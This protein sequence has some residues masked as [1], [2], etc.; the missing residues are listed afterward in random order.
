V[1][2]ARDGDRRQHLERER[3]L[4]P[5]ERA[6]IEAAP[7]GGSTSSDGSSASAVRFGSRGAF[8]A[9]VPTLVPY[10]SRFASTAAAPSRRG[11][12]VHLGALHV[13]G[14]VPSVLALGR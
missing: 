10:F 7:S 14:R 13:G 6:L 8:T 1:L 3:F 2:V 11:D 12:R 5:R 4:D 9:T